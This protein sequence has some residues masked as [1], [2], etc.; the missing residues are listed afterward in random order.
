MLEKCLWTDFIK[1]GLGI[2]LL[3]VYYTLPNLSLFKLEIQVEYRTEVGIPSWIRIEIIVIPTWI[4]DPLEECD[5]DKKKK[6]QLN[7]TTGQQR[8]WDA[9]D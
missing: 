5:Y 9:N 4:V 3:S 7:S 2:I 6:P 8:I 1:S